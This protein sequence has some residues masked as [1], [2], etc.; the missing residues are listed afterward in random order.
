MRYSKNS[1]PLV[2]TLY[3][4]L[5]YDMLSC[6]T[7]ELPTPSPLLRSNLDLVRFR[8]VLRLD[9]PQELCSYSWGRL[10]QD[11]IFYINYEAFSPY[12]SENIILKYSITW[13]YLNWCDW[14]LKS[15]DLL[16]LGQRFCP[17]PENNFLSFKN[18][19]R[20]L[21]CNNCES[22]TVVHFPPLWF[23]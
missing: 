4:S 10:L 8:G 18:S 2:K 23:N 6:V 11:S 19:Y 22:C 7:H 12:Q 15:L 17:G 16:I 21:T 9:M 13:R 20:Y 5:Q 3:S 1:K 14:D